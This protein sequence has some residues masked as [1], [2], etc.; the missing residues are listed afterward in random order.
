[1]KSTLYL[2]VFHEPITVQA[3]QGMQEVNLLE[4]T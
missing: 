3:R 2:F 4:K 1:M